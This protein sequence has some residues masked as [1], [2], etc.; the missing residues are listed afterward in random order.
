MGLTA[1]MDMTQNLAGETE[2]TPHGLR[3][4]P[5]RT[6]PHETGPWTTSKP[7]LGFWVVLHL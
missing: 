3:P 2:H 4:L 5:D 1:G 7:G 6:L